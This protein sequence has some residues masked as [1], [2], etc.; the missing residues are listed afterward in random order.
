LDIILQGGE[1]HGKQRP[2]AKYAREAI[3]EEWMIYRI[4]DGELIDGLQVFRYDEGASSERR[5]RQTQ[6]PPI[7]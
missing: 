3:V 1:Y 4:A 2:V 6:G 7:M 5:Y